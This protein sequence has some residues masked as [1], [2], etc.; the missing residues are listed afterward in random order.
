MSFLHKFLL[1][2][3]RKRHFAPYNGALAR[4][5]MSQVDLQ[6]FTTGLDTA[7]EFFQAKSQYFSTEGLSV[8]VKYT[9][10]KGCDLDGYYRFDDRRMVLAVKQRLRYPR[11]ASYG[12]GSTPCAK[13]KGAPYD[14]V[15]FEGRFDGPDDLFVFVAGHEVWHY[16]CHSGQRRGDFETRANC[17]GFLWLAEYRLWKKDPSCVLPPP[18]RP[19][20]PDQVEF[21]RWLDGATKTTP[22]T[23]QLDLFASL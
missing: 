15:W 16:L 11:L 20:R 18:V 23:Q 21:Q 7:V 14:L 10:A 9:R 4:S 17:H 6:N 22:I 3:L 19:P 2:I 5:P 8:H 13:A 1:R 12:I